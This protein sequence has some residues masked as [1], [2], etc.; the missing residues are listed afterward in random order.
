V[1]TDEQPTDE[2]EAAGR[3]AAT[4]VAD[5]FLIASGRRLGERYRLE[6]ALG[7]GGM[8]AVWLATDERLGRPVAI[9]I[10]S[11][12]LVTDEQY[13]TRFRREAH[14]AA[15]LQHPNLVTV[16]DYD[17]GERPYLVM[18]YIEGGDL[19]ERLDAGDAPDPHELARELLSALRHIHAAGVLH[20]DIK[21]QNVLIDAAGRAR[22]TDFG[23]AQP[24]NATALTRTG[25]LIG[26]ESYIA[27]E[28]KRGAPA[29]E[30]SDLYALGV[31]LADVAREGAGAPLWELTDRLRDPEP[32]RRP[33]SAA[34]ALAS[35]D[36]G[37]R[38]PLPGTATE[39]Y[40][41]PPASPPPH[42]PPV[43]RPFEP[44]QPQP[45]RRGALL[46][47]L[48]L[49][50]IAAAVIAALLLAGG[51][52]ESGEP[53]GSP[54]AQESQGTG[55]GGGEPSE[56]PPAQPQGQNEASAPPAE[57]P[58][59]ETPTETTDPSALN[60]E[61]KLLNDQGAYAEA[62]PILE[63]AVE[64]L[65]DSGDELTYNYALYNLGV[66]YLGNGQPKD[67]IKVLKERMKYDDQLDTVQATL[68]E[69]YAA[70]GKEPKA[71]AEDGD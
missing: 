8:A 66:A 70:A 43:S 71:F 4:G 1:G 16:Y 44:S 61:G 20:R 7:R 31:V 52:D 60:D 50:A 15:S 42:E 28:V 23:I 54:A 17:A 68:D 69:A 64:G 41:M 11:D 19:A 30:R 62:V 57:E 26:T 3:R 65:R 13:L 5:P 37:A 10:L 53:A 9:K 49:G 51:D 24:A 47:W 63:Q 14:T 18:E 48:A 40:D 25:H 22:L 33:R 35:L 46:G 59:A 32:E 67:A 58:S 45:R 29:S 2:L 21:P 6:R 39:T 56:E 34:T 12:T 38:T 55:G 27:P 36:R